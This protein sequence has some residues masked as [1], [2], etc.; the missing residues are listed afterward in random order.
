VDTGTFRI[1]RTGDISAAATVNFLM[2]GTAILDNGSGAYD[3]TLSPATIGAVIQATIPASQ[4]F[5][6][7][8]LTPLND[9]YVEPVETAI[10]VLQDS[11][12][13]QWVVGTPFQATVQIT[14]DDAIPTVTVTA[15][16]AHA[17]EAGP[18][19]QS[20][21]FTRSGSTVDPL[22][23]YYELPVGAGSALLGSDYTLGDPGYVVG[24][25]SSATI[26]IDDDDHAP[27]AN[28]MY[29]LTEIGQVNPMTYLSYGF[30]INGASP[31]TVVGSAQR[32]PLYQYVNAFTWRNGTFTDIGTLDP[33]YTAISSGLAINDSGV[34]VGYATLSGSFLPFH[35]VNG[36]MTALDTL[37]FGNNRAVAINSSTAPNPNRIVGYC[38]NSAGT[39]RA[40]VWDPGVA[41]VNML[42]LVSPDDLSRSSYALGVNNNGRIV[43]ES[44]FTQTG[45]TFHAFR[46]GAFGADPRFIDPFSDDLG[47]IVG[48]DTFG[49]EADGINDLDEVVG[50]SVSANGQ[51]HAYW[52][53]AN[54]TKDQGFVDLGVLSGD[55]YSVALAINNTG[56]VVGYS[57]NASGAQRAFVCYNDGIM[58][59]LFTKVSPVPYN[60]TLNTAEA[61]NASG[62]IVGFGTKNGYTRAFV[63]APNQ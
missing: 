53:G 26:Y 48:S 56:T 2:T 34:V 22:S 38:N 13:G 7:V 24:S 60:W 21:T 28:L 41:V 19:S 62:W 37:G 42:T 50:G 1:S 29:T 15:P 3:Y 47:T 25:A 55:N 27:P 18:L 23:I 8:T 63:L 32:Y 4:S 9:P 49:S 43:G 10:L 51:Y 30:G 20:F 57:R 11:Y 45:T 39:F 33:N 5:V 16:T 61:V 14:S 59:D 52:K 46:T 54:S 58:H 31:P 40:T 35:T 44:V 17:K 36:T 6:D 12:S